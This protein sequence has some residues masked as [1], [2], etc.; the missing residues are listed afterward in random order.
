MKSNYFT[1]T[2]EENKIIA[3]VSPEALLRTKKL[4]GELHCRTP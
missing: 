2:E 4:R 3:Q 1:A